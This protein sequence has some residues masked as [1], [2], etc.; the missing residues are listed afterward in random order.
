MELEKYNKIHCIGIGGSGVSA[1][2]AIL[3][4]MGKTI[5]GS[6]STG[7]E[8]ISHLEKIGAKIKLSHDSSNLPSD[9]ELIIYSSAIPD[10]NPERMEAK[11]R[12]L[13]QISYPVA[14]GEITKQK[15]TIAIC[16]THGKTT[17][18][19]MISAVFIKAGENPT[20]ILGSQS[21]ELNGTNHR[22]G[23][24]NWFILESCEYKRAFLNYYPQTIVLITLEAEHLDYYLDEEDYKNAFYDFLLRIKQNGTVVANYNSPEIREICE[25]AVRERPDIH[26]V[27]FSESENTDY[28][29]KGN[30]IT[31]RHDEILGELKLLIPGAHNRQ[32][33]LAAF[34]ACREKGLNTE[35]ILKALNEFNGTVRRYHIL[36]TVE[37][38]TIIDDYA[39]HPTEIKATLKAVR[40]QNPNAKVLVIFQP[41]QY[42]RTIKLLNQFATAF[43]DA[44]E[45]IIPNI[46]EVRDSREDIQSMNPEKLVEAIAQ[47]HPKVSYG[48]GLEN[49]LKQ[50]QNRRKEFDIII[51]MGAGNIW[52]IT[53]ELI[54][55]AS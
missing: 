32:N 41:H 51:S 2:A 21:R 24:G 9:A 38:T 18:T 47:R 6:D 40:E 50:A 19:A 36:G 54:K 23:E 49:T 33:A 45:V 17:T 7:S 55:L 12:E 46:Y 44:D 20:I 27:T 25:K 16:G 22:I 30:K 43:T 39:H 8:L 35:K 13:P 34:S 52:Q 42:S 31:N 29:L 1:L 3:I 48:G 53:H 5:S 14:V 10:S 28:S 4:G 37:N 11:K 26:V 15:D